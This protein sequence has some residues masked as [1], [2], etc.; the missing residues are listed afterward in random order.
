MKITLKGI[1]ESRRLNLVA[2]ENDFAVLRNLIAQH[3]KGAA[4]FSYEKL[5]EV[6]RAAWRRLNEDDEVSL[7]DVS[8]LPAGVVDLTPFAG[9]T[10]LE[11][12]INCMIV[13]EPGFADLDPAEQ[14]T[15]AQTALEQME[16]AVDEAGAEADAPNDD[17]SLVPE[18]QALRNLNERD[19]VFR[20]LS[21]DAKFKGRNRDRLRREADRVRDHRLRAAE[22]REEEYRLLADQSSVAPPKVPVSPQPDRDLPTVSELKTFPPARGVQSDLAR[23]VTF[24]IQRQPTFAAFPWETQLRMARPVLDAIYAREPDQLMATDRAPV[25]NFRRSSA[26]IREV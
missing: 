6:A 24:M 2:G 10:D 14:K 16:A 26:S 17:E 20:A 23:T 21:N 18:A 1:Q 7:A 3:V 15:R 22:A 8:A 13:T 19:P 11:K 4:T 5:N 12:M 9:A 25:R